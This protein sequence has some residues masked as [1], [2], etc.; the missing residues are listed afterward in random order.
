ME[1]RCDAD[2]YDF[3]TWG[4]THDESSSLSDDEQAEFYATRVSDETLAWM[5]RVLR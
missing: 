3:L 5:E 4:E 1:Y 2:D